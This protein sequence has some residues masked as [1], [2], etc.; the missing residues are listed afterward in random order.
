LPPRLGVSVAYSAS[1]HALGVMTEGL[2]RELAQRKAR[3]KVALISPG[4]VDTGWHPQHRSPDRVKAYGFAPLQPADVAQAVL[5][6][7]SVP[8]RVQVSD[9]LLRAVGQPD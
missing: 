7:L 3:T 6:I 2:R 1:K 9:V 5:Y 4:V 8:R